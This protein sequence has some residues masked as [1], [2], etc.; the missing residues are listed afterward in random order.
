M[1]DECSTSI[2]RRQRPF[3]RTLES[4][5]LQRI[6]LGNHR[7]GHLPTPVSVRLPLHSTLRPVYSRSTGVTFDTSS[8]LGSLNENS[9]QFY[10]LQIGR[11]NQSVTYV[12]WTFS[13]NWNSLPQQTSVDSVRVFSDC[14]LR[15]VDCRTGCPPPCSGTSP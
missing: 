14:P 13:L 6:P 15:T 5:V 7:C 12:W 3:R 9:T 11:R 4:L 2:S 10:R 1:F 8:L